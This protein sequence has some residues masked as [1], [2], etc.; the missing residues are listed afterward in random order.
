MLHGM[1]ATVPD[2]LRVA[3]DRLA[4]ALRS[5]FTGDPAPYA[6]LWAPGAQP[7]LFGAWGTV[8]RGHDAVTRTFTWV[9]SRFSDGED[10]RPNHLVVDWSGDLAYAAGFEE[11]QARVDG[12]PPAPL[13]LRVTHVLRRID[14]EWRLVHRHADHPPRD[15]RHPA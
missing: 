1:T 6:A 5:I 3:L 2:D 9:A 8:E 10:C 12:G 4:D 14:G 13:N 11:G 7:T 15:Q